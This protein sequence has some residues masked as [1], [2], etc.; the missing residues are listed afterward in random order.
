MQQPELARRF[1]HAM[2]RSFAGSF[3]RCFFAVQVFFFLLTLLCAETLDAAL[4]T[5]PTPI[6]L[7]SSATNDEED[8]DDADAL[9]RFCQ[10]FAL[11]VRFEVA[12][13]LLR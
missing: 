10:R 1:Y 11:P 8:V 6:S 13:G 12:G 9:E 7:A 2:A 4:P 5:V 3:C